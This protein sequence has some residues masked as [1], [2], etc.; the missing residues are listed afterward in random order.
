MASMNTIK[1]AFQLLNG[2]PTLPPAEQK[3]RLQQLERFLESRRSK[4][5]RAG[6]SDMGAG[7]ATEGTDLHAS[8]VRTPVNWHKKGTSAG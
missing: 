8:R 5:D 2:Y 7:S 1:Q 4:H 6:G 3:R